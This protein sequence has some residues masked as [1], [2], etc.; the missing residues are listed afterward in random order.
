MKFAE[1]LSKTDTHV[2]GLGLL[3]LPP[4]V[5]QRQNLIKTWHA[6]QFFYSERIFLHTILRIQP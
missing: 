6:K 1:D 2:K 4:L 3:P 5:L